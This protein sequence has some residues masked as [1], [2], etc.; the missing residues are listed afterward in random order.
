MVWSP[1]GKLAATASAD[2]TVRLWDAAK[3][4]QV[5]SINAHEKVAYAVAFH[6]KGDLSPPAVTTS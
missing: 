5:R 6:P 4:A 1:D 3:G 2:K